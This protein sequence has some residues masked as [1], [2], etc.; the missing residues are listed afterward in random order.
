MAEKQVSVIHKQ[1]SNTAAGWSTGNPVLHMGQ[2][3][4]ESDTGKI[5]VGDGVT[6]WNTLEYVA[7][8]SLV[9]FLTGYNSVSTLASLPVT[10]QSVVATVTVA[11]TLSLTAALP[12]GRAL[13]LK[14]YNN[15]AGAITQPLPTTT[16]FESKKV[17][18]TVVSSVSIPAGGSVE[19]S[20]WSI[21]EKYVIKCDA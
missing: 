14:V 10:R 12:A 1:R 3:G 20:I 7:D 18:S 21:N 6:A 9:K 15:S 4:F 17:D 16:P 8:L 5:K 11:T 2:I 19:I 13:M